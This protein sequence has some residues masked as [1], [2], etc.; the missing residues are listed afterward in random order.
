M[1]KKSSPL[2]FRLKLVLIWSYISFIASILLSIIYC[3]IPDSELNT[4]PKTDRMLTIF[5]CLIV[6]ALAGLTI[7]LIHKRKEK[8]VVAFIM[9][10]LLS[11]GLSSIAGSAVNSKA[12]TI[13]EIATVSIF[14]L[15]DLYLVAYLLLSTEVKSQLKQK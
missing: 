11:Y 15:V 10:T 1:S 5:T 9:M 8:A 13:S 2:S 14:F 12:D 6:G 7:Y 4:D 3:S